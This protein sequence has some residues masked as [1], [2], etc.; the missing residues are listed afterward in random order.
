M[1]GLYFTLSRKSIAPGRVFEQQG[2]LRRPYN[3]HMGC[4]TLCLGVRLISPLLP[5][6]H[7]SGKP[8][9]NRHRPIAKLKLEVRYRAHH[10][11]A[12]VHTD[13]MGPPHLR[14]EKTEVRR[15]VSN[16]PRLTVLD[17]S[18]LRISVSQPPANAPPFVLKVSRKGLLGWFMHLHLRLMSWLVRAAASSPRG[19]GIPQ[20]FLGCSN[21]AYLGPQ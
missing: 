7:E 1:K 18:R 4:Y 20:R 8:Q 9:A 16:A 15:R 17:R 10:Q 21:L 11:R 6:N 2:P 3:T 14:E 5:G 13:T 12:A 19:Y